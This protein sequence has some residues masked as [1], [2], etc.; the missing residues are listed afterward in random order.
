MI[1]SVSPVPPAVTPCASNVRLFASRSVTRA[2]PIDVPMNLASRAMTRT[3]TGV[4]SAR[5]GRARDRSADER[6]K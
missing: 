4:G 3:V 6:G 5:T 1:L 2:P